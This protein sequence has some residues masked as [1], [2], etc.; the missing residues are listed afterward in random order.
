MNPP[1]ASESPSPKSPAPPAV[2]NSF[3]SSAVSVA[4][5]VAVTLTSPPALSVALSIVAVA[6][7]RTSFSDTA[8]DTPNAA[9]A[10]NGFDVTA[11]ARVASAVVAAISAESSADTVTPAPPVIV[12]APT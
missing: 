8:P 5:S 10:A 9:P 3:V 12:R 7:P 11:D 2:R 6:P 4:D 1:T